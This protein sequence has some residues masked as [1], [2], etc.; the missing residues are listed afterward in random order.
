MSIKNTVASATYITS[1][2][3]SATVV[4]AF[5]SESDVFTGTSS[6]ANAI[7]P[8]LHV[9]N[10]GVFTAGTAPEGTIDHTTNDVQA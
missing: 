1:N 6:T 10:P 3:A 8:S 2:T 9:T 5:V 7:Q 4:Y